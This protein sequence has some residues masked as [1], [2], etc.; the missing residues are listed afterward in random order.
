[1]L[2]FI[3]IKEKISKENEKKIWKKTKRIGPE[4]TKPLLPSWY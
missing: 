2:F 3:S 1:M 4:K